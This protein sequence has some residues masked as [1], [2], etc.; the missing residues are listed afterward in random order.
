MKR[1][2]R[3]TKSRK[4]S[5]KSPKSKKSSKAKKRSKKSTKV[6]K[7]SKKKS[8]KKKSSKKKSSKSSS[9]TTLELTSASFEDDF[10]MR[11]YPVGGLIEGPFWTQAQ[12]V[13]PSCFL[14]GR[15]DLR[16]Q[17]RISASRIPGTIDV[18][19]QSGNPH[20]TFRSGNVTPATRS[21][22]VQLDLDEG[23]LPNEAGIVD[24]ELH[25]SYRIGGAGGYRTMADTGPS[26]IYLTVSDPFPEPYD[27]ALRRACSYVQGA[28]DA[29]L[30]LCDGVA[31]DVTY[32]EAQRDVVPL[33]LYE[34]DGTGDCNDHAMLMQCLCDAL[35]LEN[36]VTYWWGGAINSYYVYKTTSLGEDGVTFRITLPRKGQVLANAHF[37][38]HATVLVNGHLYDPSYGRQGAVPQS[39]MAKDAA[40][41]SGPGRYLAHHDSGW[42]C[43][44]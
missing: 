28:G 19:A 41:L 32:V 4:S 12:V 3:R 16:I 17:A 8:S 21:F 2:R 24:L 40:F 20:L 13:R 43:K 10:P 42:R 23:A 5:K 35:G 44:H 11:R 33:E 15:S 34:G 1:S 29:A 18:R 6:K 31:R 26:R 30:A 14:R 25:W 36:V 9:S 37:M 27:E 22:D 7:S 38:Y 39:E